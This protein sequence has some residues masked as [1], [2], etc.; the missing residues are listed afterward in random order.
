MYAGNWKGSHW[1]GREGLPAFSNH[2]QSG[3][4][5]LS[6][7]SM[8]GTHVPTTIAN[9]EHVFGCSLGH[10]PQLSTTMG[11]PAPATPCPTVLTA[12]VPKW[13]HFSPREKATGPATPTEEPTHWKWKEGKFLVGTQ[14]KVLGG[15]SLGHQ[16]IAGHQAD[17]F[18]ETPPYF[19]PGGVPQSLQSLSGDDHI[20]WPP[21]VGDLWNPRG[22]DQMERH[23]V[24][25]SCV[26]EFAQGSSIFLPCAPLRV[27]KGYGTKRD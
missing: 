19:Q 13:W 24:C 2:L 6:P 15:L 9:G 4:A 25:P 26:Q 20:S 10:F 12:P 8:S 14:R 7:R 27:T 11:Q 21:G 22:L 1:G 18:W 5:G 3:T 17:I 16:S 23:Q